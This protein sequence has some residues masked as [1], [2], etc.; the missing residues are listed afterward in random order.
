MVMVCSNKTLFTK[1]GGRPDTA[2]CQSF[3]AM[4]KFLAKVV[5]NFL[6]LIFNAY[7]QIFIKNCL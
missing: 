4:I 5:F 7:N 2:H 1:A 3:P 6:S